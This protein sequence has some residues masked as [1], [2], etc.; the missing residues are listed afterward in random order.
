MKLIARSMKPMILI[1]VTIGMLYV[2]LGRE[3]RADLRSDDEGVWKMK[4]ESLISE[5]TFYVVRD[6]ATDFFK[7]LSKE[8]GKAE[9]TMALL[10]KTAYPLESKERQ[11]KF[12]KKVQGLIETL[13][14]PERFSFV[15]LHGVENTK[16]YYIMHFL[17]FHGE[18]SVAAWEFEFVRV[19]TKWQVR[20]MRFNSYDPMKLLHRRDYPEARK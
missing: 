2:V 18:N 4:Y 14:Q 15:S 12:T 7:G 10:Y 13:G 19:K 20:N 17:T 11:P 6:I 3:S 8:G 16:R 9:D 1:V 5:K